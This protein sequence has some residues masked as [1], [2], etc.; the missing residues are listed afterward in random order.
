RDHP[1]GKYEISSATAEKIELQIGVEYLLTTSLIQDEHQTGEERVLDRIEQPL[2]VWRPNTELPWVTVSEGEFL[3]EGD[4]WK[5]YGV[6]YMPSSGVSLH[7][8][9]AFEYWLEPRGYDPTIIDRDLSR[10]QAMG[11]NMVSAFVYRRS[12]QHYN[13]ID[14]LYRCEKYGLRVNLSLRPGTP[15]DFPW[16]DVNDLISRNQLG[17]IPNVFAFDL[18]WEPNFRNRDQRRSHIGEWNQWLIAQYGSIDKAVEQWKFNPEKQA[19]LI[20]VPSSDQWYESGDWDA[21]TADYARFIE[22]YLGEKYREA[23]RLVKE[24]APHQLVSFRMQHTG[25]PTYR[26]PSMIPYPAEAFVDAVDIFEPEAYGRIGNW[27]RIRPGY[28]TAAYLRALNPNLPVF[29]AEIG[30]SCW[31]VSEGEATDEG[32]ERVA[33]FYEDFHKMLMGSHANG[34]AFWWYPGGYRVNEKSDYGVINPD[35]TDRP[36]TQMIREWGAK[37]RESGPVPEPNSWLEIPREWT[38]G[39][40][41]GKYD[42]VQEQYWNRID[43]GNEVGLRF[44]PEK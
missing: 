21:M 33:R 13:L 8:W 34:V 3:V 32:K 14:F 37:F 5:P 26:G 10:I 17:D 2:T 6:N 39:G 7:D 42:R 15:L 19:D 1:K 12:L 38:P 23:R 31:S 20:D 4:P 24:V 30:Q 35:G 41:V 22:D 9:E 36:V 27:E 25:D 18:A 11:M 16:N 44:V 43:Q 28:F 40:I 29:W